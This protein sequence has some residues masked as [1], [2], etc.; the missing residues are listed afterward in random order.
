MTSAVK[1]ESVLWTILSRSLNT[2]P[3]KAFIMKFILSFIIC[4]SATMCGGTVFVTVAGI[5]LL[6]S[7]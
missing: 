2:R 1:D 4:I 6:L 3:L 5:L 7:A